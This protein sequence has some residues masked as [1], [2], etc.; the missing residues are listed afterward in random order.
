MHHKKIN[1]LKVVVLVEKIQPMEEQIL[2]DN[3]LLNLVM[4]LNNKEW[5]L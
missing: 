3:S 1:Y 5:M 2:T 4:T